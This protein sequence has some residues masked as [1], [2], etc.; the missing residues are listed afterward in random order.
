MDD[1]SDGVKH[2]IQRC[3]RLSSKLSSV[4]FNRSVMSDS[5]W[6]HELQHTRPPCPP[7]TP[8][9]HSDS[10]PLS[11]WCH[12]T[13]SSSDVPFSPCSQSLPAS[14]SFPIT[15]N[16]SLMFN[17]N[18]MPRAGKSLEKYKYPKL[19]YYNRTLFQKKSI[20]VNI[21]IISSLGFKSMLWLDSLSHKWHYWLI[22]K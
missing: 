21:C 17:D 2:L 20:P 18:G 6:P 7:P 10:H 5:L 12:P 19:F 8:G 9:V 22:V 14:E 3:Y 15:V 13:I 4:Q 1:F 16:V 11:P